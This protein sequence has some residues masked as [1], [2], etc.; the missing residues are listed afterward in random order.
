[1]TNIAIAI[2]ATAIIE[3]EE[4]DLRVP[5]FILSFRA[6]NKDIFIR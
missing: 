5:P 1:M 6:M 4:L 3:L 2:P